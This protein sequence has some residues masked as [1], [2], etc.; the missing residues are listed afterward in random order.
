MRSDSFSEK[1]TWMGFFANFK[2]FLGPGIL[3]AVGY[4]DPGNW[5]TDL[6]AGSQF[7]YRHLFIVLLSSLMA[8]ALQYL[9]VRLGTITGR[10]LAQNCRNYFHP[11]IAIPLYIL[12]EL[13]IIAT[14]LAE[15]IGSAIGIH[16]LTGLPMVWGILITAADVL[17][18]LLF[19]NAKNVRFF[20]I[21]VSVL[22]FSIGICFA[23][24]LGYSKPD[25]GKVGL[26]Y[27]PSPDIFTK[28]ESLYVAIGIIGATVMPHNLYLHSHLVL[29][30]SGITQR[31]LGDQKKQTDEISDT[32]SESFEF[33]PLRR[34]KFLP[35]LIKMGT[36]DS[37]ISLFFA[38]LIN[39]SILIVS[40]AAFGSLGI[41]VEDL[42][43]A[44]TLM[45]T[46][47]GYPAAFLFAL[48]LLCSGQSS[49]ITGTMAGQI[50]MEG[51]L[52]VKM[53]KYVPAW[54]RRLATRLVSIV[55]ALVVVLV[56]GEK[57]L[58]NLLVLSQVVLSLQLPFAVWPLVYFTARKGLM[59][60][61]FKKDEFDEDERGQSGVGASRYVPAATVTRM[62]SES[63]TDIDVTP[64]ESMEKQEY[65]MV[66]FG[67]ELQNEVDTTVETRR[68]D[69]GVAANNESDT[70]LDDSA[71]VVMQ[72]YENPTAIIILTVLIAVLI[73]GFNAVLLVQIC[74]NGIEF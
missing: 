31:T 24:L 51:F 54:A 9:C 66:D 29:Y 65:Q 47:L 41:N 22:V 14:D 42:V 1:R 34:R 11:V 17:L 43:D 60:I 48:A 30:R 6:A 36:L 37:S 57:K 19:W 32:T 10:D 64:K 21:G 45:K 12:C 72:S 13:A 62:N 35:D 5:A 7:Q 20:E 73:T 25:W 55:P 16:L 33:Q 46:N 18:L 44:H 67:D 69:V 39:S 23:V 2:K 74:I 4:M 70:S 40:A 27:L 38:L 8:I 52:G 15:V 58:N 49:T 63:V 61:K 59:T 26:G 56:F 71:T 53:R 68:E 28:T 3:V 50:V